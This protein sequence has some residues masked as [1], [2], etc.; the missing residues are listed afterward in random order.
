MKQDPEYQAKCL[1]LVNEYK[2]TNQTMKVFSEEH[3]VKVYQL[4]YWLKKYK[5]SSK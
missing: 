1:E 5:L 2:L 4:Q 3:N